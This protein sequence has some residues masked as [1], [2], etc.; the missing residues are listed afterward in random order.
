VQKDIDHIVGVRK[1]PVCNVCIGRQ[2][3]DALVDSG[4]DVSL[5]SEALFKRIKNKVKYI[6]S[7]TGGRCFRS[8]SGHIIKSKGECQADLYIGRRRLN[9]TFFI[10]SG[11]KRD[12]ILGNDFLAH[13]DARLDFGSRTLAIENEIALLKTLSVNA[14]SNCQEQ[15]GLLSSTET[16]WISPRSATLLKGRTEKCMG[17]GACLITPLEN[18]T[19]LKDQP[20]L[21]MTPVLAKVAR[22]N[23]YQTLVVNDSDV[24][25][26]LRRGQTFAVIEKFGDSETTYPNVD[27]LNER[28]P[29]DDD[30]WEED[31]NNEPVLDHMDDITRAKFEALFDS[32]QDV[33]A[34]SDT[35]LGRTNLVNVH[36]DTKGH[37][38]IKLR[39]YRTPYLLRDKL[40]KKIEEM[41]RAGVIRP[42]TS[43]W[44]APL[45]CVPK[46]DGSIRIVLDYRQLNAVTVK[47]SYPL[48]L[49]EEI[50][51]SFKGAKYFSALDLASGYW[52]LGINEEDKAK[53]AFSCNNN[54]LLEWQVL[55]QGLAVSP[56]YFQELMN[57]VLGG[58][59]GKCTQAYLDDV[60][61]YSPTLET[62]LE[63]LAEVLDR[64]RRAGLKLRLE[65]CQFLMSKVNYLGHV[66]SDKGIEPNPEKV[67]AIRLLQAPTTVKGVRS[68]LGAIGYYRRFL[69]NFAEQAQVLTKLTKKN[70]RFKWDNEAQEA[71]DILKEQLMKAPILACPD[72][73]APYT[74][75]TDASAF[76]VGGILTQIIDGKERTIQYLSKQL[77]DCQKRWA[78]IEREGYAIVYCISKLRHYLLGAKVRV[79]TDHKPLVALFSAE[80]KNP[81]IKR[82]VNIKD[83]LVMDFIVGDID[84]S[85]SS[86]SEQETVVKRIIVPLITPTIVRK[87]NS[88]S[89][90]NQKSAKYCLKIQGIDEKKGQFNCKC[91]G[92][93]FTLKST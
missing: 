43:P 48:P 61:L 17:K 47:N 27:S 8:A 79:F 24:T 70:A 18:S 29:L 14:T 16:V 88:R 60:L 52:Q 75:Y 37:P 53:T 26:K 42:S 56:G 7:V 45:V 67:E 11:F 72:I 12:M 90:S 39:P 55:P 46:K 84:L 80:M 92:K 6:P 91:C 35:D 57:K 38:P 63:H 76:A 22:D 73:H 50:L 40:A 66:I 10:I 23:F 54:T 74:L 93:D 62:H 89:N 3:V 2:H 44:A 85:Q 31:T 34:K 9:F 1:T 59:N 64:F 86:V 21:L 20:H 87:Y 36:I 51:T 4:A 71:F 78:T 30:D 19:F 5:I 82:K 77:S 69:G 28:D 83:I 15:V 68:F 58:L 49:I 33:F 32:H 25:F 65:K 81:R 41:L 13:F